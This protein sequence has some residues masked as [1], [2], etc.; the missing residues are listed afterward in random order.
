MVQ[1]QS[2]AQVHPYAKG[3]AITKDILIIHIRW[4]SVESYSTKGSSSG[5]G[6]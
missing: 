5:G 1:I 3:V 2:L 6:L 4:G